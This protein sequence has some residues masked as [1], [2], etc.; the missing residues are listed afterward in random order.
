MVL[1]RLYNDKRGITFFFTLMLGTT[2]I[3]LGLALAQPI[4]QFVDESRDATHMNCTNPDLNKYDEA[5]CIG[6]DVL[7]V[8]EVGGL[9][10]IGIAIITAKL[11][12]GG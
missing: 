5:T 3:I 6:L 8:I 9:I 12:F 11:I 2:I 7:K 4:K 1:N 10:L